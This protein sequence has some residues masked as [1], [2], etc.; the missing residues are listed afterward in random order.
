MTAEQFCEKAFCKEIRG[1]QLAENLG[2]CIGALAVVGAARSGVR[3]N[4]GPAEVG[5]CRAVL[6]GLRDV[7]RDRGHPTQEA[8]TA[9]T[10]LLI[11][12][13]EVETDA[14][15]EGGL[16]EVEIIGVPV[17]IFRLC[18]A[19]DQFVIKIEDRRI[20][21]RFVFILTVLITRQSRVGRK[22]IEA[23]DAIELAGIAQCGHASIDDRTG[24]AASS[25][26][27]IAGGRAIEL[28]GHTVYIPSGLL[29]VDR[30]G[31]PGLRRFGSRG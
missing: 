4:I 2:A 17:F 7:D 10:V 3:G 18:G 30:C 5:I 6:K 9:T 31:E 20:Q 13:G 19:I 28:V 8:L 23:V 1:A 29:L 21:Q 16:A 27:Y 24:V 15:V 26:L 12:V 22:A 14:I 11:I 25:D